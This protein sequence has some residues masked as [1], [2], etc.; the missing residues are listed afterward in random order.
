MEQRCRSL[1]YLIKKYLSLLL[2]AACFPC[3]LAFWPR[4]FSETNWS[5]LTCSIEENTNGWRGREKTKNFYFATFPPAT[6]IVVLH[7]FLIIF[8]FQLLAS[9]IWM[10]IWIMICIVGTIFPITGLSAPFSVLCV[11]H[12]VVPSY[13]NEN[14]LSQLEVHTVVLLS[15]LAYP[16]PFISFHIVSPSF[17]SF[18]EILNLNE[19]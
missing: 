2:F 6:L 14:L 7:L 13:E 16:N 5:C 17:L 12:T 9:M 4:A 1:L 10:M 19:T 18:L 8:M 11:S 3:V 15:L